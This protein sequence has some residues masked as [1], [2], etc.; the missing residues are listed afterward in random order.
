MRRP[1]I[2]S[3]QETILLCL[4]PQLAHVLVTARAFWLSVLAAIVLVF[5]LIRYPQ[6]ALVAAAALGIALLMLV[7]TLVLRQIRHLFLTDQ[8]VLLE[9]GIIGRDYKLFP[10]AQI[11]EIT[12]DVDLWGKLFNSGS[13]RLKTPAGNEQVIRYVPKPYAFVS[14]LHMA[15]ADQLQ[16]RW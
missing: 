3:A 9:D 6:L 7:P 16:D 15:M 5:V 8:R 13:I 1:Q 12:V 14:A 4:R 10:F 11:S 2:L